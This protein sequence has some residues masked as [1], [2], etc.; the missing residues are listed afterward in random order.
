[1]LVKRATGEKH[2]NSLQFCH[3][4]VMV[5]Q[6]TIISTAF[7]GQHYRKYQSA[8]L[9]ALNEKEPSI[10]DCTPHK[11]PNLWKASLC[12]YITMY[13]CNL[14]VSSNQ[15]RNNCYEMALLQWNGRID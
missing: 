11:E 6:I 14:M 7:S 15:S 5:F 4:S 2:K 3:M 8:V 12:Q 1:M 9:P 10:T 13:R